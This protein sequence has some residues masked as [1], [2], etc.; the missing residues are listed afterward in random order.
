MAESAGEK[1]GEQRPAEEQRIRRLQG[2]SDAGEGARQHRF[3]PGTRLERPH[4]QCDRDEHRHDGR[5]VGL[6]REPERLRQE[7]VD[8]RVV[9][10]LNEEGDGRERRDDE[11]GCAP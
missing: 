7:L 5:E 2:E 8:P 11:R 1:E 3:P 4:G 10:A 9:V 6:L